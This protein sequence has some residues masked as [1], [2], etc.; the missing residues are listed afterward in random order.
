[1]PTI[2]W[3]NTDLNRNTWRRNPGIPPPTFV[4]VSVILKNTWK[5]QFGSYAQ[6]ENWSRC[7]LYCDRCF[8]NQRFF[9]FQKCKAGIN[10]HYFGQNPWQP[11]TIDCFA[12]SFP[13]RFTRWSHQLDYRLQNN[14]AMRQLWMVYTRWNSK[15]VFPSC[16]LFYGN[17]ITLK[18]LRK[19]FK[20]QLQ[21]AR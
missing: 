5:R 12:A 1:M 3:A 16:P 11:K 8:D 10:A 17:Q 4:G 6:K 13:C 20:S 2:G 19:R 15:R 14:Q 7:R 18:R 21:T 9:A